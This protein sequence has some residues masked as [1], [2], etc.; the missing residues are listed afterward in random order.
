MPALGMQ[1]AVVYC[2]YMASVVTDRARPRDFGAVAAWGELEDVDVILL[3]D[4]TTRP[5]RRN[6]SSSRNVVHYD[7][8]SWCATPPPVAVTLAE[9]AR[10]APTVTSQG[11]PALCGHERDGPIPAVTRTSDR[12]EEASRTPARTGW[13]Q[14]PHVLYRETKCMQHLVTQR[15]FRRRRTTRRVTVDPIGHP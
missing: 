5:D 8:I 6:D 7:T 15:S 13:Y 2:P 12:L 3:I 1:A 14:R 11:S 4:G 9:G 10:E